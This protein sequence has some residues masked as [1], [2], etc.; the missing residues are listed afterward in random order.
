MKAE[1]P[2]NVPEYIKLHWRKFKDY[3]QTRTEYKKKII[4]QNINPNLYEMN[5]KVCKEWERI[6]QSTEN[7]KLF[8]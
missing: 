7:G 4:K 6:N 3:V 5:L 8:Y 1:K 2:M